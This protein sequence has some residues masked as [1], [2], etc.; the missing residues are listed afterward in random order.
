MESWDSAWM[1]CKNDFSSPYVCKKLHWPRFFYL[2]CLKLLSWP[3]CAS[4]DHQMSYVW[5]P[6]LIPTW[7]SELVQYRN[8]NAAFLDQ[9]IKEILPDPSWAANSSFPPPSNPPFLWHIWYSLNFALPCPSSVP[10]RVEEIVPWVRY[11]RHVAVPETK[12]IFLYLDLAWPSKEL[13]VSNRGFK[14]G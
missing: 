11:A 7:R 6:L 13:I 4:W 5:T 12:E 1:N 8:V 3:V 9:M 2:Y 14:A 10:R